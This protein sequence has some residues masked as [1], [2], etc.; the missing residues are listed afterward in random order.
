[1]HPLKGQTNLN[2]G[3]SIWHP[4]HVNAEA[5]PMSILHAVLFQ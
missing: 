4:I 1:M 2:S 5:Q 3:T